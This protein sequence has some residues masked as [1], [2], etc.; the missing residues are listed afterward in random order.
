MAPKWL[1][2][3]GLPYS[4]APGSGASGPF[5]CLPLRTRLISRGNGR[6]VPLKHG[7]VLSVGF[8][9]KK[10]WMIGGHRFNL[11]DAIPTYPSEKY[12]LVNGKDDIPYMKW[13]IKAM[14]QTTSQ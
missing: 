2:A 10:S 7:Q 9:L 12:E 5:L 6:A 11:V 8:R 1:E 3:L 14:F 13:K 4:V